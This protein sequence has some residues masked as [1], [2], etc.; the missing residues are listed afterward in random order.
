MTVNVIGA[1]LAGCEAAWQLAARGVKVNLYDIKPQGKTPAHDSGYFGELVCS[2][3]L[4]SNEI[5]NAHGV[6]K[7][8]MRLLNSLIIKCADKCAVP[9]GSALA[10][11]RNL[12]ARAVT[13]A[14]K[15]QNNIKTI[16]GEVTRIDGD[17]ITIVCTG[18]LT[19]PPLLEHLGKLCGGGNLYFFDAAAPIIDGESIDFSKAFKGGRYG[20]NTGEDGDYINCPLDEG[21]YYHFVNELIN[22]ERAR[23][24]DFEDEKV[25]EGCL[26]VEVL[27]KRGADALRYGP[28]KPVGLKGNDGKMPFAVVQLRRENAEGSCYNMVGFQTNLLFS[29]QKR[30]FS[31]IPA[32][33][34]AVFLRYGVMHKNSYINSPRVLDKSL[35]LKEH[36]NIFIAGQLCGVEGYVESAASGLAAALNVYQKLNGKPAVDFTAETIIGALTEYITAPNENFQPM[37]A[38]F[39]IIKPLSERIRDKRRRNE[40]YARRSFDKI[41]EVCGII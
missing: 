28:L 10:V 41:K 11:D 23:L 13:D 6:L 2:N 36:Q 18:P 30:V 4:K 29:E 3:S 31:M 16:C 12:F 34:G 37:N 7:Q 26:P 27:A 14:V 40:M 15:A 39:G 35:S 32:L 17:N 24:K 22:A 5:T 19:T 21:Q 25:F 20:K 8:E 9:A 1:G 33:S 38:N